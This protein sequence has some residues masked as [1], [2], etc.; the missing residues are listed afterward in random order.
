[1]SSSITGKEYPL[2]KI[3]SSDFNYKIPSYQRPYSWTEEETK[4]L[5]D[6]LYDFYN[7]E[8]EDNYF[9]GSIVL[10]KDE[11]KPLS[12]VIDGQQRLTTLTLLLSCLAS[13]L[14]G[15]SLDTLKKYIVEPGNKIT[16][17]EAQPRLILRSKDQKVFEDY[18]QNIKIKEL[19]E[20][21]QDVLKTEAQEHIQKNAKVLM[22]SIKISFNTLDD[23]LTFCNF[24]LTRC[25]IV[26][27]STP[28]QQSAFRVFSVMNSRGMDLL[29]IDII[30][31]DII[32]QMVESKQDEYTEK[33]EN[34]EML[35]GRAGFNDIFAYTRM[36]FAKTKAKKTLLEE[37]R[38]Y[39][40][41]NV[42]PY[43][44]VDDILEPYCDAYSILKN[45]NYIFGTNAKEINNILMWLNKIDNSDWIPS[46]IKFY[47]KHKNDGAYVLW[48]IKKLE[49]LCSYQ[50]ITGK[51]VNKRIE[52]FKWILDEM[53]RRPDS[54]LDNPLTSIELTNSE[55]EEFIDKLDS[56]IYK[57]TPRKRNY[58]ILRLDS[59]VSD[60][61]AT[62]EPSLLTIEH[63]LPQTINDSSDWLQIWGDLEE[64]EYW[65]NRIA[66]LVPLTRQHNSAAQNLNFHDKKEKY[67]K[68]KN[69][70]SSYALTT[71]VLGIDEW[72]PKIVEERQRRLLDIFIENWELETKQTFGSNH[73]FHLNLR[74]ASATGEKTDTG[75]I[76]LKDSIIAKD[77]TPSL[78][79]IYRNLREELNKKMI[80][81]NGM[82]TCDYEFDSVT[83]ASCVVSGRSSNGRS[84]W[85]TIDGK[86][87]S[88]IYGK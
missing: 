71:Q 82:F 21:G 47:S 38:Q 69:K 2:E 80:V 25:F 40:L 86:T 31:S 41:P 15:E 8:K 4:E 32:G 62:Y 49:R 17:L 85:A 37:F 59:F 81:V 70:T 55:I 72:T 61:A 23:I 26:V 36:I 35:T 24:L 11:N 64:R 6:D 83:Q 68:N 66:N 43:Q 30:K 73:L 42:T 46:A 39:V 45:R 22:D 29:P 14:S 33:W 7:V 9:L 54:S 78:Q 79:Q 51:D 88:D 52:R 63:V 56:E 67:F 27:V 44:L 65:L 48:F 3:F 50:L 77:E 1:M 84:E 57:M 19:L 28:S 5:F 58:I 76:V 16:R 87:Y 75:F 74:G 60:G 10:I 12:Q 53:E 18:V 20:L 13:Q 34:L